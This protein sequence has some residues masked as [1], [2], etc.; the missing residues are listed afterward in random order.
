MARD[1]LRHSPDRAARV[2]GR[3]EGAALRVSRAFL[4]MQIGEDKRFLRRPNRRTRLVEQ[5]RFVVHF[6]MQLFAIRHASHP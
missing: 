6:D 3:Q 4:E 2:V 1:N 5:Q